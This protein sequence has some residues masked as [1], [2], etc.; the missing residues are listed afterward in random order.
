MEA[1][2]MYLLKMLICSAILF[3]YYRLALYNER[4]HQW[5]RFY[6]LAAMVLS[7]IVPFFSIPIF[8]TEEPDKIV[9]II[10]SMPWNVSVAKAS[11]QTTLSWQLILLFTLS[12]VS[13]AMF[14]RV[15]VNIT[16]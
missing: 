11:L 8:T 10:A 16:R 6:L 1:L 12:I 3:G 2:T 4:F 7:V 9:V 5:N 14:I 15:A 13:I